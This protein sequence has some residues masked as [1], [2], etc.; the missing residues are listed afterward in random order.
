M[1]RRMRSGSAPAN[2]S[3]AGDFQRFGSGNSGPSFTVLFVL[4]RIGGALAALAA[5]IGLSVFTTAPAEAAVS[6]RICYSSDST[7]HHSLRVWTVGSGSPWYT[8]QYGNCS[9]W[10]G[11]SDDQL[12]VNTCPEGNFISYYVIKSDSGYGPHHN[13]CNSG[14]NPPNYNGNV[15]Y[16][17]M[18]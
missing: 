7:D 11:N 14:S 17:M 15:Y 1:S 12:R 3:S 8:V 6:T 16:K 18:N 9:P 13:G 10:I 5:I 2:T 4:K